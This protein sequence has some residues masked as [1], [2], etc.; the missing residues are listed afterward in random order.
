[1][2][3]ATA[4]PANVAGRLLDA[5]SHLYMEPEVMAQILEPI[6]RDWVID[7]L[8]GFRRAGT[9][10][11]DKLRAH[12][13]PWVVKGLAALGSAD[14]AT[15][16]QAMDRMG[17]ARQFAFPNTL[18]REAR[19]ST[20]EAWAVVR[21]YN[22]YCMQWTRDSGGRSIGVCQINLSDPAKAVAEARR[23]ID[24]G[25]KAVCVSFAPPPGGTSPAN[26]VWDELWHLLADARVPLLAHLGAT[27]Q[28]SAERDDPMLLPRELWDSPTLRSAFPDQPGAEERIGP[29]WTIIAPIGMEVVLTAM[30]MGGVFERV[31]DLHFG[32][33]EFGAQWLG[34]LVERMDLHAALMTKVGVGLPLKPSEYV[35]RNVRVT[36]FWSEPV[37]RYIERYGLTETMMFSTDYPHVEGGKDPV[38]KFLKTLDGLGED[39]V[40]RFFVTNAELLFQ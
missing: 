20:P 29:I 3:M 24:A 32:I 27:G 33:I 34:P 23:V 11:A 13:D 16:V 21:N 30:V 19:M 25:A 18:G 17:I 40:E 39:M 22:D 7:M 5:D 10:E 37:D 31:P 1:M 6:G 38:G 9:F 36:P 14:G 35:A 15:R 8:A 28:F 26:P 4:A 12:S 2:T